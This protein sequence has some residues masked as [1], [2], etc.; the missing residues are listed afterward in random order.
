MKKKEK[1]GMQQ[2]DIFL[3]ISSRSPSRTKKAWYQYI[4]ICG[5]H[6]IEEKE[7]VQGVSGH[8]L[9]LMCAVAA[10]KRMRLPSMITIHT[11]SH[12]LADNRLTDWEKSGWKRADGK[13]LKNKDLW[14]QMS[15]LLKPHAV[16]FRL[17]N[18]GLYKEGK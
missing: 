2:V 17:E 13:E 3:V 6:R 11:D 15:G 8:R 10:L 1:P 14:Q 9:L 7:D 12:Y 18:M 5:R 4:L 16:R